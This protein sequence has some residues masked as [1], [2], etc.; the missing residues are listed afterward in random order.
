MPVLWWGPRQERAANFAALRE[1][2]VVGPLKL[3]SAWVA[4]VVLCAAV[5]LGYGLVCGALQAQDTPG[6][7]ITLVVPVPAGG[8]TMRLA[9]ILAPAL[10]RVMKV[11]VVIST[12]T[13]ENGGVGSRFVVSAPADGNTLLIAPSALLLF[14]PSNRPERKFNPEHDLDPLIMAIR[15]PL[16]L[17]V[18]LALPVTDLNSFIAY[19]QM[20]PGKVVFGA[21]APGSIND[22]ALRQFWHDTGTSGTTAY[23]PS[24]ARIL[25]EL[26]ARKVQAAFLDVGVVAPAVAANQLR[27]LAANG[28]VRALL[29]HVPSFTEQ[30][31][32]E[33]TSYTWQAVAAPVGMRPEVRRALEQGLREALLD[34]A[35][36]SALQASGSEVV[37][38]S[39]R[40][41]AR[42]LHEERERARA[43][44]A[45]AALQNQ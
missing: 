5:P 36:I 26:V 34:R 25:G 14:D 9:E 3:L 8:V 43:L 41:L 6:R 45:P 21:T 18:D 13:G 7:P 19:L 31:L 4:A 39:S 44:Q 17:A 42:V 38:S 33:M 32:P 23:T 20:H 35:V 28:D 40:Q 29:P 37:A 24:S 30:G 1:E 27:I 15:A 22:L 2:F 16:V 10:S 12:M 11:P